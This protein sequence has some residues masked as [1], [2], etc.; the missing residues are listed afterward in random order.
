MEIVK[1]VQRMAVSNLKRRPVRAWCMVFFVFM[2]SAA[3]FF[4]SI[5]VGSME[6]T[7]KKTTDRIGADIIV[8]P[9][10]FERDMA[11][12]LFLGELCSF[13]FDRSWV[14]SITALEG[15]SQAT[16]QLYME[17]L[18]ADCC[19]AATQLIAF[20][21][22]TDYIVRPWLEED[23]L[24]VPGKGQMYIGS[25]I[26]PSE[27]GKI[28][29]FGVEYEVLGQLER[30]GTSYDTCAFMTWDTAQEIMGSEDW[31]RSFGEPENEANELVSS[32]MIR[33]KDGE[34]A[35]ALARKIN[36]QLEG[37]PV[38]AYTTNGIF[39]GVMESVEGMTNYC[40]VLMALMFLL[41]V[42]ALLSVFTITINERTEEFGILA[43]LGV[44]S[45]RLGGIVLT[46]GALIG[47]SGGLLGAGVSIAALMIFAV[48]IKVHLKMPQLIADPAA[49]FV[50]ASLCVLL[51]LGVS[52][53]ASFYSAW[54]VSRTELDGLIKGE[55][56]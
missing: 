49:L 51:S 9:K 30:T 55:E 32:I 38:A 36:Y 43:S 53:L 37:A 6:G 47:L 42:M 45:G 33:V 11:D 23:N 46:E 8:V 31:I 56:L 14:E 27:P 48:P 44:A 34:N 15:I 13:T 24:P 26:N 17:S 4:S 3:L 2:L 10:E 19:S 39:N 35:K 5:L 54:K 29:F 41:V 1:I 25:N 52:L 40:I 20:D 7:L 28:R 12:S 18:A 16:P 21:P 50:T 22:D